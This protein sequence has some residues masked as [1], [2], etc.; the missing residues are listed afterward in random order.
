MYKW[1]PRSIVFLIGIGCFSMGLNRDIGLKTPSNFPQVVYDFSNNPYSQKKFDLGKKLFYDGLLSSD[2]SVSCGFCHQQAS[3][4]THHGHE[5]SHGVEGRLGKRNAPPIIN[6]IWQKTFFWDGGVN[7]LDFVPMNAIANPNEM[8][9]SL[10]NVL[11]KLN[12]KEEYRNLVKSAFGVEQISTTEFLQALSIYM[13]SLISAEAKYDKVIRKEGYQFS[14]SEEAGFLLF[15]QKCASCHA[16]DLFTDGSYRNNGVSNDY[17]FDKGREEITLD[18]ADRGKYKVP[19]LRN[20]DFTAP[21]MHDGSLKTIDEVLNHY[22][23]QMKAVPALDPLFAREG[24]PGIDLSMQNKEDLKN[25]LHTLN[26]TA[27]LKNRFFSE[28]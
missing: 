2:G 20:I 16:T 8:N 13:A 12:Q 24:K 23:D 1:W 25:F 6:V 19:T 9:E 15:K 14:A 21:Y 28:Y 4:F 17:R 10:A 27:F 18:S 3:S 22:S 5:I 26:D 11:S 7:H